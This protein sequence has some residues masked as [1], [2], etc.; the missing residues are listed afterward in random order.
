MLANA[1]VEKDMT[2]IGFYS[3]EGWRS[4]GN[5]R[6]ERMYV[7]TQCA[8]GTLGRHLQIAASRSVIFGIT[9]LDPVILCLDLPKH[10]APLT[11]V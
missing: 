3:N 7:Y 1:L 10:L 5:E 6:S 9:D 11:F 2:E 8:C 4:D